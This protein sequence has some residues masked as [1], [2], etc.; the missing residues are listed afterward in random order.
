MVIDTN[1]EAENGDEKIGK[2]EETE[3]RTMIHLIA[4][5][6][7]ISVLFVPT[8]GCARGVEEP[9]A[10]VPGENNFDA[11]EMIS[12]QLFTII[13]NNISCATC[14][15]DLEDK[16]AP[17]EFAFPPTPGGPTDK[18]IV[19]T[20][21]T[22][23]N[24]CLVASAVCNP[25]AGPAVISALIITEKELTG[26]GTPQTETLQIPQEGG[27]LKTENF[28]IEFKCGPKAD[29]LIG[30]KVSESSLGF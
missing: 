23:P 21:K 22:A 8:F 17:T 26:P 14:D 20:Y 13:M 1:A 18:P 19:F 9:P 16:I 4:L 10:P 29:W 15:E 25:S 5:C 3:M 6:F 24:G 28:G 7:C 27:P 2:N 12:S 11:E 30:G